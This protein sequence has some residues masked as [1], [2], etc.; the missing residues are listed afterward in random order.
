[1][2]IHFC[3]VKLP[4]QIFRMDR[5][6]VRIVRQWHKLTQEQLVDAAAARAGNRRKLA[7]VVGI[8]HD[9]LYRYAT[10]RAGMKFDATVALLAYLGWLA[11]DATPSD[12]PQSSPGSEAK[13]A[14]RALIAASDELAAAAE[15]LLG[16][17][18]VRASSA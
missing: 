2:Q 12:A 14:A 18:A 13:E 1:M 10:G 3:T 9:Y 11:D 5:R 6:T 7:K 8:D 4:T 15:R 16:R 17:A